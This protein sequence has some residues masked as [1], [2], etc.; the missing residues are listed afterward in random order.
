MLKR[1]IIIDGHEIPLAVGQY[2]K[3]APTESTEGVVGVTYLDTDS[4]KLYIC[5]DETPGAFRWIPAGDVAALEAQVEALAQRVDDLHYVPIAISSLSITNTV[6]KSGS[7]ESNTLIEI[8]AIVDAITFAWKFSR[9]PASATFAGD[10]IA[11]NSTGATKSGLSVTTDKSWTLTATGDKGEKV[12]KPAGVTFQRGV[13]Y[14][15]L[16]STADLTSATIRSLTR[17]LQGS[18]DMTFTVNAGATQV[19]V[20]A[21]PARY[22]TPNFNVGGFD[23]GFHLAAAINFENSSGFTEAYNVW[24]SD[25]PGLGNTTVKVARL[26]V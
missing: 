13:Y 9:E 5:T 1:R 2:G 6:L 11:V 21:L 10:S 22:G 14:G 3:G 8:G 20:Y 19:I 4:G 17:K 18:M 26:E 23:G 24:V 25:N 15:V 16:S 12:S 7:K